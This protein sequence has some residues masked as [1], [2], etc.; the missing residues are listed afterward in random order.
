MDRKPTCFPKLFKF[1]CSFA[2][3]LQGPHK[4]EEYLIKKSGHDGGVWAKSDANKGK[5]KSFV[6]VNINLIKAEVIL[7]LPLEDYEAT[8]LRMVSQGTARGVKIGFLVL[9]F[10]PGYEFW[11]LPWQ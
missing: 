1:K 2:V 6:N 5:K 10:T 3:A 4:I 8:L 11:L 7:R 9:I